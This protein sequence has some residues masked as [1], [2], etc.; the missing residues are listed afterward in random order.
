MS[1]N[2]LTNRKHPAH[3]SIREIVVR[4]SDPEDRVDRL[5][6]LLH[7]EWLADVIFDTE[8]FGVGAVS[9]AFV[10]GDHDRGDEPPCPAFELFEDEEAALL[11]HHHVEDDEV[12]VLALSDGEAGVAVA[13]DED[14]VTSSFEYG[15]HGFDDVVVVVHQE[16]GL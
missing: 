1:E 12:G 8:E 7:R 10:A 13:R 4:L 14:S 5:D 16:D 9:A 11:G 15:P 6:E 2:R 3:Y